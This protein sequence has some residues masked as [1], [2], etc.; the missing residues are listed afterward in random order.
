VSDKVV[1]I[2]SGQ[3]FWG[4]WLEAPV[5]QVQAGPIDYLVMDYLAEVTMSILQKQRNRDPSVGYAR[6]FVPLMGRILPTC[7][8]RGIRVIANAGGVNPLACSES[9]RELAR[10]I[11]LEGRA[12]IGVITGD[13]LMDRLD[14]LLAE[15]IE[16]RNMDTDEPLE[17]VR[18]KIQSANAY[19]GAGPML[20]ALRK[21]A[22]VVLAGRTTDTAL[23]YAPMMFEHGWAADD[24]DKLAAGVIAGH[25]NECGA[26]ATGGNT[27]VDW[28]SID[29]SD[30]GYPIIE[31]RANGEFVVT[32]HDGL[33][34]RVT[35]PTVTEQLL[36]EM[37]DPAEY[38]TPDCIADFRT[39]QL[40]QQG[41][42]RVRVHGVT[43]G[44]ATDMLKV[45]ISYHAGYKAIGRMVY[46]WPDAY[47]KAQAADRTIRARLDRIGLR[48]AEV[49]TEYLG[50]GAT[51]G[52][53]VGPLPADLPEVELR[54]GVKHSSNRHAVDRFTRE[55]ASLILAGPPTATGFGGGRPRVQEMVA[56]WPALIPKTHVHPEV[57]VEIA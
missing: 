9:V 47:E 34:G 52:P 38:I 50:A 20:E 51:H 37:G 29:Y 22:D 17:S 27:G 18:D 35:V 16:L 46:S 57:H 2:A 28:Q 53:L 24:W 19:I 25:I 7:I 54:I 33:G 48:F 30:I 23:T 6:D 13:D 15:G 43:G 39:I 26:Q 41:K 11:G 40:E 10:R 5:R 4:D 44:P 55:I 1:R 32:K 45:S 8:E 31:S 3:G 12:R 56:Y 49:Y 14:E 42:D 36:Y 21:G